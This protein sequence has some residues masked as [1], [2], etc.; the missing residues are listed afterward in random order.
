MD[1]HPE[2]LLECPL[3]FSMG[4]LDPGVQEKFHHFHLD[5]PN[6]AG[7]ECGIVLQT[8]LDRRL[9]RCFPGPSMAHML[10]PLQMGLWP[11]Q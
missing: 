3:I 7:Q 8:G 4:L 1:S 6:L 5:I 11:L 2:G 10:L 9:A